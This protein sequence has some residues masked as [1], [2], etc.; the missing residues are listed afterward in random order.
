MI[1]FYS[2]I[3]RYSNLFVSCMNVDKRGHTF[4]FEL[5]VQIDCI[6]LHKIKITKN[7]MKSV[8]DDLTV[9]SNNKTTKAQ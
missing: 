4:F 1:A 8:N 9:N 7:Y 2:V 3:T 6:Y 5:T